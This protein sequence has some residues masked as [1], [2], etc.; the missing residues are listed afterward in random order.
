MEEH[1]LLLVCLSVITCGGFIRQIALR[2][3]MDVYS[4][5]CIL[6]SSFYQE[7]I[8]KGSWDSIV[9]IVASYSLD[10][11][12]FKLQYEQEIFSAPHLSRLALRPTQPALH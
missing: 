4:S 10:S 12:R 1:K 2:S 9:R 3:H 8:M 7:P 11:P 6:F 5:A